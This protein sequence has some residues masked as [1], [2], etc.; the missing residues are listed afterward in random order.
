MLVCVSGLG[1]GGEHAA[2]LARG[3]PDQVIS[4]RLMIIDPA[5]PGKLSTGASA[6]FELL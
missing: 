5:G 3:Q 4:R 2:D 6:P 1:P